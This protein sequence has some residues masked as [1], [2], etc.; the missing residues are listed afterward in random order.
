VLRGCSAGTLTAAFA[1]AAAYVARTAPH[2]GLEMLPRRAFWPPLAA[3]AAAAASAAAWAVSA[4]YTA[5]SGGEPLPMGPA[6]TA[7]PGA[8]ALAGLCADPAGPTACAQAALRRVGI[9]WGVAVACDALLFTPVLLLA[10]AYV[11]RDDVAVDRQARA[12]GG[13]VSRAQAPAEGAVWGGAAADRP[14]DV[15]LEPQRPAQEQ[16]SRPRRAQQEEAWGGGAWGGGGDGGGDGAAATEGRTWR[17]PTYDDAA[18][19][20]P[21]LPPLTRG[22]ALRAETTGA[23][24]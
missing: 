20:A 1:Y 19:S 21:P 8:S 14:A 13:D 4:T 18:P 3:V 9:A 7:P 2:L 10:S 23:W 24:G 6:A 17:N 15:E 22:A 11:W 16:Q 12:G 5:A